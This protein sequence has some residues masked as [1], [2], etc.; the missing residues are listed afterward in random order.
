[1][2]LQTFKIG[3]P[4]VAFFLVFL[5]QSLRPLFVH[6]R[7]LWKHDLLHLLLFAI[8]STL[9]ALLFSGTTGWVLLNSARNPYAILNLLQLSNTSRVLLALILFDMWMYWWHR[10]NHVVPFFWR[11]HRM[12]HSDPDMNVTTAFRF[13]I[14]ELVL[15]TVIRWGIFYII[16]MSLYSL[17]LYST[18]ILPVIYLQH[19]NWR[20]PSHID[21]VYRLVFASPWMHWVHHSQYQ[22]ET[23]SNYGT[24]FSWWDRLFRSYRIKEDPLSIQY[25]LTDFKSKT[26]Q[27]L[28]GLLRTPLK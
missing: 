5:L 27:T 7:F 26:W 17:I 19:S 10:L 14:G 16:G 4:L 24:L 6:R 13:H 12:H 25:G 22:P 9:L 28:W 20:V 8:N 11:F 2:T 21:R 18:I 23:D 15:S 3:C 1:M